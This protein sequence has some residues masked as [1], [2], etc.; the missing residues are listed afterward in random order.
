VQQ[1]EKDTGDVVERHNVF[2]DI[3]DKR[4]L[5]FCDMKFEWI[6]E[7]YTGCCTINERSSRLAWLKAG[8]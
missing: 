8:T 2:A 3:R 5:I 7:A 1:L 4:S 6:R